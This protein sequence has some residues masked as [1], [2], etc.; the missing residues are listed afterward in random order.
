ML[1]V[2]ADVLG[3]VYPLD[4]GP[5]LNVL[6]TFRR[7]PGRMY[8]NLHPVSGGEGGGGGGAF[9]WKSDFASD[10]ILSDILHSS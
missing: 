8:V 10:D 7:L 5:K 6:K 3:L 4:I 1:G 2:T 9:L